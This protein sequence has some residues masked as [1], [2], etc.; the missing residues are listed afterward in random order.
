MSLFQLNLDPSAKELRLFAGLWFP[1]L[2]GMIG[3]TVFRKFHAPIGAISIWG[4]AG[5]ISISGLLSPSIIRP[6]YR[7]IMR[8]SFPAGWVMS[9][10][11]L[12]VAYFLILTPIGFFMRL[13]HDPMQRKFEGA[14]RSYWIPRE[15]PERSRYFRQT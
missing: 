8:L 2:C 7:S 9:H 4:I 3:W 1:A 13:F 11:V 14:T 15:Q 5:L 6:I 12:G 10:I